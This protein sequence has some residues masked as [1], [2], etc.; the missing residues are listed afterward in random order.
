[1]GIDI[2]NLEC[3]ACGN[4][5]WKYLTEGTDFSGNATITYECNNCG[6][7]ETIRKIDL[8]DNK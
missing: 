6:H 1:M 4:T 8:K 5:G 2:N 7:L 3:F